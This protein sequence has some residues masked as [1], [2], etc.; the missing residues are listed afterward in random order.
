MQEWHVQAGA[1]MADFAGWDMPVEFEGTVAE[2]EAVRSE[3]GI[4]DVSH[5]GTLRVTGTMAMDRLN[6]VFTNDL[7]RIGDGMAQ[8][9][10]LLNDSGGVVDDLIVYRVGEDEALLIPNAANTDAVAR[11]VVDEGLAVDDAT[12]ATAVLAL[13]GPASDRIGTELGLPEL[14]FMHF[15]PGEVAGVALTVC[16]TG[17]TGERG[18][19]LLVPAAEALGVWQVLLDSGARPCGLGARDTL[20]TEMGYPLHGKE[21]R[22]DVPASWCSVGWAI[23]RTKYTFPGKSALSR[24]EV[25]QRIMGL[26]MVD[27]GIP[28]ADMAVVRRGRQAGTTT[29]G[30]FS[31]SL[32]KGIAL[33]RVARAAEPGDT[34]QIDV[35]GRLLGAEIVRTPFVPSRVRAQ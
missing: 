32:G 14:D 2:H 26:R 31:P 29:S 9:T 22:P 24:L 15:A 27:R 8:Y 11:A 19:E 35:R 34:V 28:R 6:E 20:R 10:L 3:V 33:A 21:L 30:T 17:Y 13:Q 18:L 5:L 25:T 16:R 4:F 7:D 12:V 23:A 1:K